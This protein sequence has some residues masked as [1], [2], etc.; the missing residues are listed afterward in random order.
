MP[1]LDSPDPLGFLLNVLANATNLLLLGAGA[2]AVAAVVGLWAWW[3]PFESVRR[4]VVARAEEYWPYVPWMLRLSAGLLLL[5]AGATRVLFAPDVAPA[6]WPYILLTAL[7]FMLL[8]GIG[9]RMAAVAGLLIYAIGLWI[10]PAL[11]EI[12]DVAGAL[13]AAAIV[14]AG[15]PSLD[16]LL[17]IAVGAARGG[18]SV[19]AA[20][21]SEPNHD[22]VAL[23]VRL[24]LGGALLASGLVDKLLVYNR[25]LDA[26]AHY[27]LTSVIPVDPGLWVVGAAFVESGLGLAIMAGVLT[28]A[29]AIL[30]FAVLTLTLFALPDDPVIA[31]VGLFGLSSVLVVTGGGRWSVDAVLRRR[32]RWQQHIGRESA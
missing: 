20:K 7:G 31:H 19:D 25:A 13:A 28:R 24:G 21:R 2:V 15:L 27:H 16:D 29:S 23:V 12:W 17:R 9:V 3:R 32:D 1:P 8:L 10:Q 4:T 14:G 22:R 18:A 5:G 30:A 26:V 11:V 6:G